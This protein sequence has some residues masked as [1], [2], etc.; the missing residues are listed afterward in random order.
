M[1]LLHSAYLKEHK[2]QKV[3]G[4]KTDELLCVGVDPVSCTRGEERSQEERSRHTGEGETL[5]LLWYP[6]RLSVS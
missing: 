4:F 2:D 1:L 3:Q 6:E 5:T